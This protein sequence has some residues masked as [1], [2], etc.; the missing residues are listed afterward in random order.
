MSGFGRLIQDYLAAMF[1]PLMWGTMPAVATELIGPGH[2]FLIATVRSLG[3]GVA[4][5]LLF[6][7]LPPP[8]WYGRVLVLGTVNIALVF[9]LFFVSASR[10]PG[11][12]IAI[13]MALSPFWATL[14]GWPLLGERPQ[15]TRLVL[16][17]FGVIGV[18]L[19]VHA[20]A[21]RLD[22]TGILA[23]IAASASMGGG[24][25]L[26]KKWGRPVPY[27]VFTGWQLLAGGILLAPLML[28]VEGV[29]SSFSAP[30]VAGL[31]YLLVA[32]TVLAYPAWFHGIE[33]V[34]AQRTSMLLL[35]VP[36]VALLIDVT[37][38]GKPMTLIQGLGALVIFTCLSLDPLLV[39]TAPALTQ[40][41]R[42]AS[43]EE[44]A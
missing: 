12:I 24:I 34:G 14:I 2:P 21:F 41:M 38:L 15:P 33:R 29:P 18:S 5:M 42:P 36:V 10:V 43:G 32:A 35:L 13:L 19:L 16:I 17:A 6:R 8:A 1:A 31:L 28:W 40:P 44:S 25:V 26:I 23:G 27:L 20:S 22:A 9:A 30:G 7:R 3:G 11:G 4:L 39:R 37:L